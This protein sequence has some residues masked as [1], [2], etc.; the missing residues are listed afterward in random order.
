MIRFAEMLRICYLVVLAAAAAVGQQGRP[1]PAFGKIP[2][3]EW[4]KGGGEA[5]IRW[6]LRMDR[7]VL[8]AH[9]RLA[10]AVVVEVDGAEF[11]K[12]NKPGQLVVFVE[13]RDQE[14]RVYRSHRALLTAEVKK[15]GDLATLNFEQHAFITPG[16]YRVAAAVYDAASKEHSLKQ[17]KVRVPEL[18]RD[19][20]P[21]A[22]R[23]VPSVELLG[24]ADPPDRWYLPEISSRLHLPVKT[25]RP[26]HIDVVVN[27]SPT[28]TAEARTG[29]VSRRDMGNLVPALK[30]I[31]Q[32]EIGNGSMNVTLLD[33]ERRK[34]SFTQ[35]EAGTLDWTRL[36][37]ALVENDPDRIDVHALENH[38]QNAQFFVSE[39]RKRLGDPARVLIVLSAPMAFVGGQDLRPIEAEQGSRVFYICYYPPL[40]VVP[41]EA[42]QDAI[43]HHGRVA[44]SPLPH[45]TVV[46]TTVEDSLE[47]TLKPLAPR[48]FNVRSPM[49][50]RNALAAIINEI[51]QLK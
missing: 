15:P 16:E 10:T 41:G 4:L 37:A 39:I 32:M 22:W 25:E 21:E 5:R 19:P 50:F 48:L 40:Q 35:Q 43:G 24:G 23:D 42:R 12:R 51:S 20:L 36:R 11:V 45:A 47:R 14:N 6:S 7:A 29:R 9:Q 13:I 27:E 46:G 17:L 28:E 44:Q 18:P 2:F 3:E 30:V 26:V 38:E 31:S 49:E 33:L 8:D 1:D 34:V